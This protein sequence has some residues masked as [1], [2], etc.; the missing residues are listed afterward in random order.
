MNLHSWTLKGELYSKGK[1]KSER[2][3]QILF[4]ERCLQLLKNNGRMAMV[5]PEGTFG[6]P[7]TVIFGTILQN[8]QIEAI[9]S[10]PSDTFHHT[11]ISK[12]V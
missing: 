11:H 7:S 1:L 12:Q 8:S 6:N 4:I 9:I 3:P 5:L 2:P 10:M